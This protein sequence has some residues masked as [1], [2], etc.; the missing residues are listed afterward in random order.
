MAARCVRGCVWGKLTPGTYKTGSC[1]A[2]SAALLV[3][4][5]AVSAE[6]CTA[7][8]ARLTV[9]AAVSAPALSHLDMPMPA[10]TGSTSLLQA[11]TRSTYPEAVSSLLFSGQKSWMCFVR[12][13]SSVAVL[14]CA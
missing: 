6:P 9:T 13:G 3:T 7:L 14:C 10:G 1:W 5:G 2:D 8:A 12:N 11:E 4:Q